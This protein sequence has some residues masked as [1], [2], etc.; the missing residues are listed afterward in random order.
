VRAAVLLGPDGAA[1]AQDSA[2]EAL[3]SRLV[4]LAADLMG[5]ADA[6][7]GRDRH[8]AVQ[9]EVSTAAGMVFALRETPPQQTRPWTL[10]VVAKR[11][12]LPSL[13][14]MDL[15]HVMGRLGPAAA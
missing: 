10:V 6:A 7:A 1:L 13:M 5:H 14:F 8:G 4:Q 3:G 15:R 2:S 12:A 9:V 11:F